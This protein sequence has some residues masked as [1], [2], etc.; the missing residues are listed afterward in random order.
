LLQ[1]R[2][3]AAAYFC[4][5]DISPL[6]AA[7]H[8]AAIANAGNTRRATPPR[9]LIRAASPGSSI[10]NNGRFVKRFYRLPDRAAHAAR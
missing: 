8:S 4:L 10:A 5:D 1:R 9:F 6:T 2:I 3:C 7:Q